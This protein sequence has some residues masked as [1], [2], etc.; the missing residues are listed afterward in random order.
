MVFAR[1]SQKWFEESRWVRAVRPDQQGTYRV[2]GLPP[3][4]YLA[5]AVDYVE[6]GTWNDPVFIESLRA[7]GEAITLAEG[8]TRN[9]ALKLVTP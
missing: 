3:G 8:E 5:I 6:E 1:D 9:I 2:D 4:D 7:H